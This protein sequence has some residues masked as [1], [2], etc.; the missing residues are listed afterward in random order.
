VLREASRHRPALL[1][2]AGLLVGLAYLGGWLGS[3]ETRLLWGAVGAL[4]LLAATLRQR[5][6]RAATG[7]WS[8][9][10]LVAGGALADQ[11][12]QLR[13]EALTTALGGAGREV[14][15]LHFVGRLVEPVATG[16]SGERWLRLRGA[17]EASRTGSARPATIR[18]SVEGDEE[19]LVARVDRLARGDRVRVWCRLRRPGPPRLPGG[20]G[21]AAPRWTGADAVGRVKSGRLVERLERER[22]TPLT[23]RLVA[24]A[25]R[26]LDRTLGESGAERDLTGAMLLGERSRLT[27]DLRR[28]LRDGGMLHVTAISGLHVGIVAW[29]L[30][31]FLARS[32]LGAWPTLLVTVC[33]LGGFAQAVGGRPS[34]V[35]AA[36]GASVMLAGRCIGREGDPLNGLCLLAAVLAIGEP[37]LIGQAGF[38]LTFLAAAGIVALSESIARSVPLPRYLARAVGISAAAYLATAP[39][40][41]FHFGWLAPVALL[42]NLVAVPLCS[43]SLGAGYAAMLFTDVPWLGPALGGVTGWAATALLST[44]RWAAALPAG[45]FCVAPPAGEVLAASYGLL[46]WLGSGA[47]KRPPPP[48][49]AEVDL[50]DVGQGQAVL[51]RGRE[52]AR[53]LVDAGGSHQPGFDPGERR[54]LP[55]LIAHG[56]R[57]LDVL[58]ISHEDV[59]HAGGAFALLREIEVGELWIGPDAHRTPRGSA[60]IR[61]AHAHGV[62]VVLA[63]AGARRVVGGLPVRVLAPER[64]GDGANRNDRSVVLLVGEAPARL[65]VPGDLEGPGEEALLAAHASLGSEALVVA[66]HGSRHSTSSAFLSA[67]RPRWALISAGRRNRFQHPHPEV[68]ERLDRFDASV[69]RT[70]RRGTVRLRADHR[71]W[72]PVPVQSK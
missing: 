23:D 66:H 26:R 34:V 50:I 56:G 54:V 72:R 17:P 3:C 35:R 58:V 62:A 12:A 2:A 1:P 5:F 41:A 46:A 70:D 30:L 29:L 67:V 9:S 39:A 65:L 55:H 8:L 16:S 36:C 71:G 49:H 61:S 42:S 28:L 51:L 10:L 69:L 21:P 31:L 14:A 53:L 7:V 68:L 64:A 6:P 43:V 24:A 20:P 60:L 45:G 4:L 63:E 37:L 27:P 22:A 19:Q 48:S 13:A 33:L 44:A 47:G 38:Q 25:R 11:R 52:G 18:L 32:R 57:R 15:E 59:D 40:V